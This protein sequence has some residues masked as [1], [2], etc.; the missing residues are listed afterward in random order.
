MSD[1]AHIALRESRPEDIDFVLQL[2]GD[3]DNSP[4]VG[5]WTRERH[6]AASRTPEVKHWVVEALPSCRPIGYVIALDLRE[7]ELGVHIKRIVIAEKGQGFGRAAMAHA[8]EWATNQRQAP[9]VWLDVLANNL[10]A[11]AAYRAAG[12][13]IFSLPEM[14]RAMWGAAVGESSLEGSLMRCPGKV[15]LP[16]K[17]SLPDV[18]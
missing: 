11:Q 15:P 7:Q 18:P 17:A 6:L 14:E 12:F 1:T 3:P 13:A 4:W 8:V 9:F 2:E 5:S 16:P 10:R